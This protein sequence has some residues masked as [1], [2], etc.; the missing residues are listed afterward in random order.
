MTKHRYF[1]KQEFKN[2]VNM[3]FAQYYFTLGNKIHCGCIKL[4]PQIIQL[5][6]MLFFYIKICYA[7]EGSLAKLLNLY[8][9][10]TGMTISATM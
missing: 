7:Q 10:N 4:C 5:S 3:N 8:P 6:E 2:N 1:P 9:L